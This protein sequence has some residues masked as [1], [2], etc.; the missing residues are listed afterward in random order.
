[1]LKSLVK[2]AMIIVLINLVTGRRPP[3]PPVRK[4][5]RQIRQLTNPVQCPLGYTWNPYTRQCQYTGSIASTVSTCPCKDSNG[6]CVY[7]CNPPGFTLNSYCQCVCYRKVCQ[8]PN[9][10]FDPSICQCRYIG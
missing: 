4:A 6:V 8:F 3:P 2:V 5:L 1:M 9:M 10:Y 7:T